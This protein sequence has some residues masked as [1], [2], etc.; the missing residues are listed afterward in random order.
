MQDA[1]PINPQRLF[2]ELNTHLPGRRDRQLRLGLGR[3]L[4]RPRREARSR[5]MLASLSGNARDDGRPAF[6]TRSPP[7]SRTRT[8]RRSRSSATARC[9]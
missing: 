2:W 6:P 8:G 3:E 9:R 1:D 5:R 4:V 7:S